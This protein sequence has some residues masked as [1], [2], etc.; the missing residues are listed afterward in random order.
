MPYTPPKAAPKCPACGSSVYPAEQVMAGDRKPYHK[1]C[2]KCV[3]CKK[4]LNPSTIN[5]HKDQLFCS[6]CYQ[7][8]FNP[9]D[10][11]LGSYGGIVT[12][13]DIMRKE[14]AERK[15]LEK[16][17]RAKREKRCPGC[18]MKAYPEDSVGVGE[19]FYHKACLKCTE[20]SRGPDNDTPMMLG[21]KDTEN[22]FGDADLEPYCKFCFAKR[23][24]ISALNISET[25]TTMVDLPSSIGL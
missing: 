23:Y 4:V 22:V 16:A 9:Q 14:E 21:P 25:V 24:K 18:D 6:P 1:Q 19:L 17:E 5:N 13:E 11:D 20:C 3:N 15:K 12:P 8:I 7:N 10:Y 2:V